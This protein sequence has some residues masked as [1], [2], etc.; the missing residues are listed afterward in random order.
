[1]GYEQSPSVHANTLF[2][3]LTCAL[4]NIRSLYHGS[5]S[6]R[7]AE[8]YLIHDGVLFDNSAALH[9]EAV[10]SCGVVFNHS[11]STVSAYDLRLG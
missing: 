8:G 2:L 10:A 3:R 7:F 9:A 6:R 1:M 4:P 11:T 5:T